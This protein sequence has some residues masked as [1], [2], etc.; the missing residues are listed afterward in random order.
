M[1]DRINNDLAAFRNGCF[2]APEGT[3]I[4]EKQVHAII[5]AA[6]DDM[7]AKFREMGFPV[8]NSDGAH[9]VEAVIFDWVRK[10]GRGEF[11]SLIGLGNLDGDAHERAVRRMASDRD[12]LSMRNL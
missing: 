2:D 8:C 3:Y 7:I 1:A 11:E 4:P 12:F 6:M 9:N 10:S 5:G